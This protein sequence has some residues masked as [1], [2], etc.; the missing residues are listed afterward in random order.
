MKTR[1]LKSVAK[2]AK[3]ADVEMPWTRGTRRAAMIA[4]RKEEPVLRRSA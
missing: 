4:K 3:T 1:F 2:T